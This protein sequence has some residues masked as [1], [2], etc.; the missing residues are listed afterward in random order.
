MITIGNAALPT[1]VSRKRRFLSLL[2]TGLFASALVAGLTLT[3]PPAASAATTIAPTTTCGNGVGNTGGLG[4]ICEITIINTITPTG[5][6]AEVTVLECQAAANAIGPSD[7]TTTTTVLTAPVTAVDQCN[8][9]INGG[10]GTLECSVEVTNNFVGFSPGEITAA[11]VNQCN[12]SGVGGLIDG[13][14]LC[15]PSPATTTNATITQCNDSA[16]GGTLVLLQCTAT[17]T[18][19]SGFNVT[20][21]QCNDSANGGGAKVI[22]SASITNNIVAA[23]PGGTET[24]PGGTETPPGGTETPPKAAATAPKAAATASKAAATASDGGLVGRT[25]LPD[26]SVGSTGSVGTYAALALGLL[27]LASALKIAPRRGLDSDTR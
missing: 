25:E 9:S 10:G 26:T 27:A 6:S 4:L 12:G 20:I 24:P 17:G 5:G 3:S 23:P 18:Q 16:N 13:N 7:C 11:T 21:D 19:A 22:C 8:G 1:Q 14:I 15:N 2:S